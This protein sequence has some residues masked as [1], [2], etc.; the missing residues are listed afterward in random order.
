MLALGMGED[1]WCAL[2]R[3]E[4]ETYIPRPISLNWLDPLNLNFTD[5]NLNT[6]E[7]PQDGAGWSGQLGSG[8][9]EK[10]G[11]RLGEAIA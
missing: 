1:R 6:Y 5:H 11:S 2:A 3:M 7:Y 9:R 8:L 10:G 4:G